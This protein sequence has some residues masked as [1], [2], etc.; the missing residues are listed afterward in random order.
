MK[1]FPAGFRTLSRLTL[2]LPAFMYSMSE[3][4]YLEQTPDIYKNK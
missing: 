2:I 1:C 4:N 3:L